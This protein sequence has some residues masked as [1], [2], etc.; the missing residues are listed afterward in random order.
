[1]EATEI[2]AAR[3]NSPRQ[4]DEEGIVLFVWSKTVGVQR[5]SHIM[6]FKHLVH[7]L[8]AVTVPNALQMKVIWLK[9]PHDHV[10]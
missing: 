7:F 10:N 6:A 5:N 3:I 1:M 8:P 4:K 2:V 9:S